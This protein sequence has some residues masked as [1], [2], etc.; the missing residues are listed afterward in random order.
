MLL[1]WRRRGRRKTPGRPA[2]PKRIAERCARQ[3]GPTHDQHRHAVCPIFVW[4]SS[5]VSHLSPCRARDR[6]SAAAGCDCRSASA[7][8]RWQLGHV[9]SDGPHHRNAGGRRRQRE[10]TRQPTEMARLDSAILAR[11]CVG[12][13]AEWLVAQRSV[14][15]QVLGAVLAPLLFSPRRVR[16]QIARD[17]TSFPSLSKFIRSSPHAHEEEAEQRREDDGETHHAVDKK[18]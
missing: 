15:R 9:S 5:C 2:P 13:R 6:S 7:C 8:R 11:W 1:G 10:D 12:A 3:T 14:G 4:L 18:V 17:P 16:S